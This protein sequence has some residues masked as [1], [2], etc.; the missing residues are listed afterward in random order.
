MSSS[1]STVNKS[2]DFKICQKGVCYI[3]KVLYIDVYVSVLLFFTSV[4]IPPP[5]P[6][7]LFDCD[8]CWQ[9]I[10]ATRY[11]NCPI[12]GVVVSAPPPLKRGSARQ[13]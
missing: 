7:D 2:C 13:V 9:N 10:F 5:S 3:A 8:K 4:S 11:D 12:M 6:I 1:A